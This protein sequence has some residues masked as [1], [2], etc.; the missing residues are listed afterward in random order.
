MSDPWP[1]RASYNAE[2]ERWRFPV[3]SEWVTEH[4]E[5]DLREIARDRI[6]RRDIDRAEVEFYENGRVEVREAA[7]A[8]E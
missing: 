1:I 3:M 6:N 4:P 8:K 2:E 7:P 5:G